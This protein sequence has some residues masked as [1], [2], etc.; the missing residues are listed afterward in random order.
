[1][2]KKASDLVC[3]SK[4][5]FPKKLHIEQTSSEI[6]AHYKS[7]IV[8]GQCLAD[9]TGGF[10]VDSYY[11][12]NK[13]AKVFHC[14]IDRKLSEIAQYNFRVLGAENVI[15]I[16]ENGISFLAQNQARFDWLYID[17]SRR[18]GLKGKVFQLSDCIPNVLLHLN[19]FFAKAD[20]ILIKTSPLLDI[21][22][23]MMDLKNVFQ[24]HVI[25]LITKLKSCSGS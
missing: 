25:A 17:P 21:S 16:A 11:F 2:P 20:N 5:Y 15:S 3:K 6:T 10:G 22:K 12:S 14:E 13:I 18:D 8:D 7:T 24:I 9:L 4:I 1:M 19:L 23:G